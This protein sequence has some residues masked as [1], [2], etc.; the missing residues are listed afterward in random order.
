MSPI[1]LYARRIG[2]ERMAEE[3]YVVVAAREQ[4]WLKHAFH[5]LLLL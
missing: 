4:K 2:E 5:V 3:V 1:L